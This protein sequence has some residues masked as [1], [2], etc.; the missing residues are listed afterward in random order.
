MS[1]AEIIDVGGGQ[2]VKLPAEFH[3]EGDVVSIRREGNAVILEPVGDRRNRFRR[4]G[5]TASLIPFELKIRIFG[6]T[7]ADATVPELIEH[8]GIDAF[9]A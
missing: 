4:L 6:R 2:A 1:T 9:S 5:P 3:F 7:K 8:G